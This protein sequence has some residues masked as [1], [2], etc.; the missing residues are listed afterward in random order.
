MLSHTKE[1]G[2]T[3]EERVSRRKLVRQKPTLP[4]LPEVALQEP[5]IITNNGKVLFGPAH[6][7]SHFGTFHV[8][9]FLLNEHHLYV[10]YYGDIFFI[11]CFH[12]SSLPLSIAVSTFF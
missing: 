5:I 10:S 9:L 2:G 6:Q 12:M 11:L 4:V 8:T 1:S 7:H 3:T